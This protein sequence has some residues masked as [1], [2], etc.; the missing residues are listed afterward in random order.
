MGTDFFVKI[1]V[2]LDL[3]KINTNKI[4]SIDW[5][6]PWFIPS[7]KFRYFRTF[8]KLHFS[9]L[10]SILLYPEYQKTI[11]SGFTCPKITML[12]KSSICRPKP[13]AFGKFWFFDFLKFY[14]SGLKSILF[15]PEYQRSFL[16]WF[17]Q[18]WC[19]VR[20]FTKTMD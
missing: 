11:F 5:Q 8:L 14:F 7:G 9:G 17:S 20:F 6:K 16:A 15:Y 18:T 19:K 3:T 12:L 13:W 2:W 4:S 1:W 10:K